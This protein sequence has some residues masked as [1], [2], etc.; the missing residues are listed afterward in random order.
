M[1]QFSII[2]TQLM[3]MIMNMMMIMFMSP[4]SN[5]G[6]V[7]NYLC[8]PS[9]MRTVTM[10]LEIAIIDANVKMLHSLMISVIPLIHCK[11]VVS[12]PMELVTAQASA[13]RAKLSQ[14]YLSVKTTIRLSGASTLTKKVKL[15][16]S[17]PNFP[18]PTFASL[19]KKFAKALIGVART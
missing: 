17:F 1:I 11:D 8:R 19:F 7:I 15:S 16:V 2:V 9:T 18:A 5:I 12:H 6:V 14:L 3:M 10:S 4:N 13:A